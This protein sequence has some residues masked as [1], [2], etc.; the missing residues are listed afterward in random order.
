[1]RDEKSP[2]YEPGGWGDPRRTPRAWGADRAQATFS[3][4]RPVLP[5][6]GVRGV[7]E[8]TRRPLAWSRPCHAV[9]PGVMTKARESPRSG[10][11]CLAREGKAPATEDALFL[12]SFPSPGVWLNRGVCSAPL[13]GHPGWIRVAGLAS[14]D[15]RKRN[16]CAQS[17]QMVGWLFSIHSLT[18]ERV[19]FGILWVRV[20]FFFLRN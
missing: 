5:G 12:S 8:A 13:S 10:A 11:R 15:N 6:S 17:T 3:A 9:P 16:L 7:G 19:T 4:R 18:K 14:A 2:F 20:N 1:V